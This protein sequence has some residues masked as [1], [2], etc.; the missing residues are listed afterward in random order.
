MM[1]MLQ[2]T[3]MMAIYPIGVILIITARLGMAEISSSA[4]VYVFTAVF[5]NN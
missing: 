4:N 3:I 5:D 1:A 2:M